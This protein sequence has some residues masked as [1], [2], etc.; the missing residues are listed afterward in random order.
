MDS[1]KSVTANFIWQYTLTISTGIDGTTDPSPGSYLCDSA[2]QVTIQAIPN[3]GYQF[4][5]WSGDASG[6]TNPII[7]TM[8]SDKSIEANF[9][10]QYRLT[11][12]AGTG[13]TTSPAPGNYTH[14]VGTEVSITASSDTGY[15]FSEW[16]GDVPAG[17]E[18]DNPI[19]ITMDSDKSVKANFSAIAPPEEG[20]K[21][22]CFIA[23]AAYGSPLHP[24]VEILRDFRDAYLMPNE[25]GRTLIGLYYKYSPF[26]SNFIVR[27]K[28]LKIAVRINLLPFVVFSYSMLHFGPIITAVMLAFV[29]A[30]PIFFI[31]FYQRKQR[32][33]EAKSPKALASRNSTYTNKNHN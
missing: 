18:N 13:G 20:K 21:G 19:T 3:S 29:F 8:D 2:T 5:N 23:T 28:V 16:T 26:L 32:R 7:I 9:I 15:R 11:T 27:H 17:H 1:D 25:I 14:D 10:W 6:T 30:L 24:Y 4:S 33:V 22:R 31:W 12:G